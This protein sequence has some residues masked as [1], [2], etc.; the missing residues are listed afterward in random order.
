MNV[1]KKLWTAL[2]NL[3]EAIGHLAQTT[4]A[5]SG[6]L[7]PP[8][9]VEGPPALPVI[10]HAALPD[11]SADRHSHTTDN[12]HGEPVKAGGRGKR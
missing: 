2:D 11:A 7:W 10:D 1:L 9:G 3:A 5:I 8:V 4:Y 12:G 6:E